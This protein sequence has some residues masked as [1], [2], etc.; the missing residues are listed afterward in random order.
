ME[1]RNPL[2]VVSLIVSI[3]A[4]GCFTGAQDI[5]TGDRPIVLAIQPTD[6]PENLRAQAAQLEAFLEERSGLEID[7]IIPLSNTGVIEALNFRHADAAMLSAWPSYLANKVAGAEVALAEKREVVIGDEPTVQPFYFSYY[8]VPKDSPIQTLEDLRGKRVAFPSAT[9]TSGY[10]FPIANLVKEGVLT[11]PANR[12]ADPKEF[13]S[14]V[15]FAGNYGAGWIALQNGQVDATVIAGDVSAKLYYEVLNSTRVVATQGP[16]P[17][18]GVVVAKHLGEPARS[19]LLAA[20][21]ELKGEHQPLMRSLVSAI[22]V[23]YT[24]TTTSNHTASLQQ[25]LDLV[26]IRFQERLG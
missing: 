15:H 24:P 8:V 18:H 1:A 13:F 7:I 10:V 4:A 23:E 26:G 6:N 5:H 16:V 19:K 11:K 9:S 3:T 22:F 14:S 17:S 21:L 2:L 12:E 25:A 20:F